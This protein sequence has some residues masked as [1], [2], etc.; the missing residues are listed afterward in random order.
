MKEKTLG[1]TSCPLTIDSIWYCVIVS[2]HL[3]SQDN[4]KFVLCVMCNLLVMLF[5]WKLVFCGQN[6]DWE[7]IFCLAIHCLDTCSLWCYCTWELLLN[8]VQPLGEPFSLWHQ[9]C[10]SVHFVLFVS[11][12]Y[13]DA[14]SLILQAFCGSV[15]KS[16]RIL[17]WSGLLSIILW[18][19]SHWNGI[20]IF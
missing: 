17:I 18:W 5:H 2:L 11:S 3:P 16:S 14:T 1:W 8:S 10:L 19:I 7:F 15:I 13:P 4:L 20:H 12:Q 9:S 6:V